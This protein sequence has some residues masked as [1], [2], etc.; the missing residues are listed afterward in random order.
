MKKKLLTRVLTLCLAT[1]L[2]LGDSGIA[3]AAPAFE[4]GAVS[5]SETV[6]TKDVSSTDDTADASVTVQATKTSESTMGEYGNSFT[7]YYSVHHDILRTKL[8][9]YQGYTGKGVTIAVVGDDA[10]AERAMELLKTPGKNTAKL[11]DLEIG[12]A[13]D[14]NVITVLVKTENN[15]ILAD[16]ADIADGI[17]EAL[18]R[19]ADIICLTVGS[20]YYSKDAEEAVSRA[21]EMGVPVFCPAGD[22][23]S[24][25]ILY[26]G[27]TKGAAPVAALS[28]NLT[29]T[30]FSSYGN[31]VKYSMVLSLDSTTAMSSVLSAGCASILWNQVQGTGK[32][33]VD[34]LYALMDRNTTK[35]NGS[36][37]GKGVV[38]LAKALKVKD[39]EQAPEKPVILTPAGIIAEKHVNVLFQEPAEDVVIY[40]T[41]DGTGPVV[42]GY[43][44]DESQ[45]LVHY[46]FKE[47]G[48]AQVKI[49]PMEKTNK[50]VIRAV[51]YNSKNGL[52]SP[53]IKM[54]YTLKPPAEDAL[55]EWEGANTPGGTIQFYLTDET[56]QAAYKPK[57]S[58]YSMP[59]GA[60]KGMA[61]INSNGVAK[62]RKD[63]IEGLYLFEADIDGVKKLAGFL[64]DGVEENPV[65][66][67]RA[68][69]KTYTI[70]CT[71]TDY[72]DIP[73]EIIHKDGSKGTYD[74]L[75]IPRSDDSNISFSEIENGVRVKVDAE[76]YNAKK[77]YRFTIHADKSDVPGIPITIKVI[78]P[79]RS[80]EIKPATYGRYEYL[81]GSSFKVNYQI[82]TYADGL[83][84]K[85]SR[86]LS[87][88]ISPADENITITNGTV[89]IGKDAKPGIY[90][91][92]AQGNDIAGDVSNEISFEVISKEE[93]T[94][95]LTVEEKNINVNAWET[96][97]SHSFE[98]K[99][100]TDNWNV[101]SSHPELITVSNR[102]QNDGGFWVYFDIHEAPSRTTVVTLTVYAT[103]GSGK[104]A[105][106]KVTLVR[107]ITRA[108]TGVQAGRTIYLAEGC[109][110][111]LTNYFVEAYG[112][113]DSRSKKVTY[114]V[115]DGGADIVISGNRVTAKSH[116]SS[117]PDSILNWAEITA[118]SAYGAPGDCFELVVVNRL[119]S[120]YL[121]STSYKGEELRVGEKKEFALLHGKDG[122][123]IYKAKERIKVEVS[124]EGMASEISMGSS[125]K[126]MLTLY[127]SKPGTYRVTIT[128]TDG[129]NVKKTY[130]FKVVE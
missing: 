66:K 4:G 103:D 6:E 96:S 90:S 102:W 72:V 126:S 16:G 22:T 11:D 82:Y 39:Y 71:T 111:N 31:K 29:K 54:T 109:S 18:A 120:I 74:E 88:N 106:V 75:I 36:G 107:N 34:N 53:E 128:A 64:M 13:P 104:K 43:I 49:Y 55:L 129:S 41:T 30:F 24:N 122:D 70:D 59:D 35:A 26:P 81:P 85:N 37:L 19:D 65:V 10:R 2:F 12:V 127:P 25:T 93:Q 56:Y 69:K 95:Y 105:T 20:R 112:K 60:K 17:D 99:C 73:L 42:R 115:Y 97:Y 130:T 121:N 79:I 48:I 124:R 87:W 110:M 91:I 100:D 21:Y 40:Y 108:C 89:K 28:N 118:K 119:K 32:K 46:D 86:K 94:K 7:N 76:N 47:D 1:V 68:E 14:A 57:W 116:D 9:H 23:A 50:C 61:T 45:E 8:V 58:V 51:A 101:K 3:N 44:N 92:T 63:A 114:H 83:I 123:T 113:A 27:Y 33:R 15:T 125:E 78:S 67:L 38:N 62:I 98:V 52:K 77:E 84:N 80:I 5:A 117:N